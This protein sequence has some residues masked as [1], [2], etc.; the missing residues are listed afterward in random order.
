M[1]QNQLKYTQMSGFFVSICVQQ[2][3]QAKHKIISKMGQNV[4]A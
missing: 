2:E 3:V 4:A 1:G